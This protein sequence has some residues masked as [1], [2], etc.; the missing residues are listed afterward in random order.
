MVISGAESALAPAPLQAENHP[1][2]LK[3]NSV[4]L[5]NAPLPDE[6]RAVNMYVIDWELSH[7]SS[8]AFDLGQMFAEV[9]S[10]LPV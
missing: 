9:S 6:E 5:P 3:P 7:L 10:L 2:K 1:M 8:I 4:L